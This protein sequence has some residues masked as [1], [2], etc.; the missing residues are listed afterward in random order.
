[1]K[2]YDR[3]AII[4]AVLGDYLGSRFQLN[5]IKTKDF[6]IYSLESETTD[7]TEMT[8][9]IERAVI[10]Y[11]NGYGTLEENAIKQMKKSYRLRPALD[12][13]LLFQEWLASPNPKPYNSYGNGGAMRVS[14]C[15]VYF[16]TLEDC[17]E[18]A[19]IVTEITHNHPE[20]LKAAIATTEA[21][22]LART[23]KTKDEIKF[24]M[25]RYYDF[26]TPLDELRKSYEFNTQATYTME[27]VLASFFE[28][29]SYEDAI[30][31]AISLGGDSDT[32][33]S[34]TGSI[35]GAFYNLTR[36]EANEYLVMLTT[37]SI[38]DISLW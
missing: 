7:D 23:N 19:K 8:L 35:A 15:G 20:G 1:M 36:N 29:K 18:C 30:R 11:K 14:A 24:A 33:A 27:G 26:N 9:A 25:K 3:G 2:K 37:P 34:I 32:L 28:S 13:G 5:P 17:L 31:N 38:F 4:G 22:F 16:D 12:Y 10:H 6:N 21:I